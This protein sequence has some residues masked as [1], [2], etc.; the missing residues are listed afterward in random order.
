M[1]K[2]IL[3][4]KDFGHDPTRFFETTQGCVSTLA[5]QV[6]GELYI[7]AL[8]RPTALEVAT[9]NQHVSM[10]LRDSQDFASRWFPQVSAIFW[11]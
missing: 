7:I 4:F 11:I 6:F 5:Q 1:E 9:H 3:Y 10:G 8:L 2:N